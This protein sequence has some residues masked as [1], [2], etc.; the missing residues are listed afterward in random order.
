VLF[1]SGCTWFGG[2][3]KE[4]KKVVA[5]GI[6]PGAPGFETATDLPAGVLAVWSDGSTLLTQKEFDEILELAMKEQPE[7]KGLA[8]AFMPMLK[9]NLLN[10]LV[11]GKIIERW[12]KDNKIDQ[13]A[14]YKS[15]LEKVTNAIKQRVNLEFFSKECEFVPKEKDLRDYYEKNKE[16]IALVTRGGVKAIGVKFDTE[17]AAKAFL[18]KAEAKAADFEKLAE[19]DA[20]LAGNMQDFHYVNDDS[21]QIG[22]ILR[23]K[24]LALK[25]FP[26]V[27]LFKVDDKTFWVVKADE[28][29]ETKYRAYDELKEGL[30]NEVKQAKTGEAIQKKLEGLK[31]Q[32]GVKINEEIIMP[33]QQQQAPR[34]LDPA[35]IQEALKRRAEAEEAKKGGA[36]KEAK[37]KPFK[38]VAKAA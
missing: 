23:D 29:Q 33:K 4:E 9:R 26:V 37:K 14:S 31:N 19:G 13:S 28:R 22:K 1:L 7:L 27:K 3:E 11:F 38:P 12:M 10:S 24:I 5:P 8:E 18:A 30:E 15:R 25:A 17:D 34:Q 21:R 20:K 35:Q 16:R 32:Y 6:A 36:A 2:G